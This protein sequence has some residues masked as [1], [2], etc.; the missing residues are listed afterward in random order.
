[1]GFVAFASSQKLDQ[2]WYD[3]IHIHVVFGCI[4]SFFNKFYKY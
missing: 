4:F 1:M 3:S 2:D